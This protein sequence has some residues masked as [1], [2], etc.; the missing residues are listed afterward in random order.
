MTLDDRIKQSMDILNEAIDKHNPVR[1]FAMMSGGHDSLVTAHLTSQ[2]PRFSAVVHINTGIGV[3][4]TRVFVRETCRRYGWRLLEYHPPRGCTYEEIVF[5][6]GFPGPGWHALPYS[7][8]KERAVR[9]LVKDHQRNRH[10]RIMLVT[11]IRR[12]ESQRRMG[13]SDPI[14]RE[15]SR[16]WVNPIFYWTDDDKHEYME[17]YNLPRNEVV[18]NLHMSGECL[19]GAFAKPGELDEIAF[20]YPDV[21]E[22]IRRLERHVAAVNEHRIMCGA[23]PLPSKW[24][25]KAPREVL[26]QRKFLPLCVGCEAR[27]VDEGA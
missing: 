6:F 24:G 20:F 15:G 16:V 2:H 26:G 22:R 23:P 14:Q 25:K 5:Q 13:Y 4:Q 9:Q 17:R 18:D 1:V 3:E 12:A 10:D 8:L 7:R 21:A 11:G 19:C 27:M